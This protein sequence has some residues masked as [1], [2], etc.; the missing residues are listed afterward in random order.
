M[1]VETANPLVLEPPISWFSWIS[2][3]GKNRLHCNR[4]S[5]KYHGETIRE[6]G[7]AKRETGITNCGRD[8]IEIGHKNECLSYV[9]GLEYDVVTKDSIIVITEGEYSD[10]GVISVVR[11]LCTFR[12]EEEIKRWKTEIAKY[13][14][15][16]HWFTNH[17]GLIESLD[18]FAMDT[19]DEEAI[20]LVK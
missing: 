9:C 11:A 16:E 15:F 13:S 8:H 5:C 18:Y 10:N 7:I 6:T 12:L 3:W 14:D 1:R 20:S 4:W 2:D 19:T 17:S